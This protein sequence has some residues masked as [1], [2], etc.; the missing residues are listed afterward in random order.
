MTLAQ[1]LYLLAEANAK[2]KEIEAAKPGDVIDLPLLKHVRLPRS[3]KRVTWTS[4]LVV[5]EE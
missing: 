5:E 3:K 2:A 4:S 1:M